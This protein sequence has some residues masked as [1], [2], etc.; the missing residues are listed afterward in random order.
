MLMLMLMLHLVHKK[1]KFTNHL[2]IRCTNMREACSQCQ[3]QCAAARRQSFTCGLISPRIVP[4]IP[5]K[6]MTGFA[7]PCAFS[8]RLEIHL[9]LLRQW[10]PLQF[11]LRQIQS[12]KMMICFSLL[13]LQ[14]LLMA[15][16]RRMRPLQLAHY[17]HTHPLRLAVP[18][19]MALLQ[20][21]LL[22]PR[23]LCQLQML[24]L[25]QNQP[26]TDPRQPTRTCPRMLGRRILPQKQI[27]TMTVLNHYYQV[28][29]HYHE[30]RTKIVLVY[31]NGIMDIRTVRC[32]YMINNIKRTTKIMVAVAV[33]A[34]AP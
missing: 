21:C 11:Q 13:V 28:A 18:M 20:Q 33:A 31:W 15:G 5:L 32:I 26:R 22:L 29:Q 14:H 23:E 1:Y 34:A 24:E 16:Y 4:R 3:C 9:R 19:M 2:P 7:T 25:P 27:M 12:R 30:T 17:Q 8:A 10:F 6:Q